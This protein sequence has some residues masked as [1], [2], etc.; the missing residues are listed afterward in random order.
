MIETDRLVLR[1]VSIDDIVT[2]PFSIFSTIFRH[3]TAA[4]VY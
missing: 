2:H 1:Q 3:I 4:K